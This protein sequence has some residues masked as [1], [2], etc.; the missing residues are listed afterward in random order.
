MH[1][2][3]LIHHL[4]LAASGRSAERRAEK[5]PS[6]DAVVCRRKPGCVCDLAFSMKHRE[7]TASRAGGRSRANLDSIISHG[8]R[9]S[10]A[11]ALWPKTRSGLNI[12]L[13][14]TSFVKIHINGILLSPTHDFFVAHGLQGG[15]ARPHKY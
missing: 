13:T 11:S 10:Q 14:F 1:L 12:S 3:K 9:T 4:H 15:P 7:E 2:I 5:T 8:A 6:E